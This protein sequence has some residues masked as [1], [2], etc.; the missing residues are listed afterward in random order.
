MSPT[1]DLPT[2]L[3]DQLA[4]IKAASVQLSTQ[5]GKK[6]MPLVKN[7]VDAAESGKQLE[8]AQVLSGL[9]E[10]M[11]RQIDAE[12]KVKAL[13]DEVGKYHGANV[14]F[15]CHCLKVYATID[16]LEHHQ[17]VV[18]NKSAD[19]FICEGCRKIYKV[20]GA[21]ENHQEKNCPALLEKRAASFPQ[22]IYGA[23]VFLPA[24]PRTALPAHPPFI[25]TRPL[26]GHQNPF[27]ELPIFEGSAD[28]ASIP[29]HPESVPQGHLNFLP[30]PFAIHT[31]YHPPPTPFPSPSSR[32]S[33]HNPSAQDQSRMEE[34]DVLPQP[35][36]SFWGYQVQQPTADF[37]VLGNSPHRPSDP[38]P[39]GAQGSRPPKMDGNLE[40][41]HPPIKRRRSEQISRLIPRALVPA[42]SITSPPLQERSASRSKPRSP[43]KSKSQSPAR[44]TSPDISSEGVAPSEPL[45]VPVRARSQELA[46]TASNDNRGP[47]VDV[48][49][50]SAN[51]EGTSGANSDTAGVQWTF[52][53]TDVYSGD[54]LPI[55][56]QASP[57][58]QRPRYGSQVLEPGQQCQLG[59]HSG[60]GVNLA[61][62]CSGPF[63]G[64]ANPLVPVSGSTYS[65]SDHAGMDRQ[66]PGNGQYFGA[67]F[68]GQEGAGWEHFTVPDWS[69]LGEH[70]GY[71]M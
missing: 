49:A 43:R 18:H 24:P 67:S 4:A 51:D 13:T 35:V 14:Y 3:T 7:I 19:E 36:M 68:P 12:E 50:V 1:V 70:G 20:K 55:L 53:P 65:P 46:D 9:S 21:F 10:I 25:D 60:P 22:S 47:K 61:G 27:R 26:Y 63:S 44:N 31:A 69:G 39:F 23:P 48:T 38:Y 45:P 54:P 59:E 42:K 30:Q 37:L 17:K 71:T 8:V 28:S 66:H 52:H 57:A 64:F 62:A 6:E 15:K 58:P 56:L 33:T 40:D 2:G 41:Q 34:L 16:K 32:A 11:A 29:S 5:F